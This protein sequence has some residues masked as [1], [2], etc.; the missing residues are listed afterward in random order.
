[1]QLTW[2]VNHQLL[3]TF[4]WRTSTPLAAVVLDFIF[5][6]FA[7]GGPL[8]VRSPHIYCLVYHGSMLPFPSLWLLLVPKAPPWALRGH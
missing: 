3:S 7:P 6:E 5:R 4:N 8:R 2:E 1:M